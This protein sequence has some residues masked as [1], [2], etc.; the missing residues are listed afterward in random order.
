[1]HKKNTSDTTIYTNPDKPASYKGGEWAKIKFINKH[2]VYP[3]KQK[4]KKQKVSKSRNDSRKR[5]LIIRY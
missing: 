3:Q 4:K 5:R 2:L 1:M